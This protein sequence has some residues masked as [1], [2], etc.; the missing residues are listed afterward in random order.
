M[1]K[2]FFSVENFFRYE[3]IQL[4]S[5][6]FFLLFL[7]L[8]MTRRLYCRAVSTLINTNVWASPPFGSRRWRVQIQLPAIFFYLFSD[9]RK[10]FPFLIPKDRVFRQNLGFSLVESTFLQNYSFSNSDPTEKKR[11][12][13]IFPK[14]IDKK[15][16]T[17]KKAEKAEKL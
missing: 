3:I 8:P 17:L 14:K 11:Y 6:R 2:F 10:P 16:L 1:G 13:L 9:T 4:S 15:F 12:F 7:K 5:L